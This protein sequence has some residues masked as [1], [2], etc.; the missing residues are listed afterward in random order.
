M[1]H[2]KPLKDAERHPLMVYINFVIVSLERQPINLFMCLSND[3]LSTY[4][5]INLL[6]LRYHHAHFFGL[7]QEL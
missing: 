1:H 2:R 3:N 4:Q 5:L 6:P 7:L